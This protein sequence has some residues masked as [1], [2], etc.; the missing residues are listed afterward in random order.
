[1]ILGDIIEVVPL[2]YGK[3]QFYR[4]MDKLLEVRP[5]ILKS[6]HGINLAMERYF[7][8]SAL[9]MVISPLHDQ[10]IISS[11]ER[12]SSKGYEVIVLTLD[13]ELLK[14][15][16]VGNSQ[17]LELA[18]RVHRIKRMDQVSELNRFCRVIEWDTNE[19]LSRYFMEGRS[20]TRQQT[21]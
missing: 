18:R 10:R 15:R 8:L 1:V 4:V 20:S 7:H 17:A 6:T 16:D 11:V 2:A 13:S 21:R 19:E 3:R 12:L 9:V 14:R 5:G